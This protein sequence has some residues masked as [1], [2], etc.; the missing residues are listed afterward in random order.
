MPASTYF[1]GRII[2]L[3]SFL[4][5][6]SVVWITQVTNVVP[7]P[8]LDEV[9]HVPQAQAYWAGSWRRWD[10]K[11]T[12]PPGLYLYSY[13]VIR[14]A[15]LLGL[16]SDCR[17]LELRA[18]NWILLIT[19]PFLLARIYAQKNERAT[20]TRR[21]VH[22]ILNI[23]SFPLLFFF[24]ALYYTDL[25]STYVVLMTYYSHLRVVKSNGNGKALPRLLMLLCGLFALGIRQTNIFW[26]AIFLGGLHAVDT[27]Q[28]NNAGSTS[29]LSDS[30]LSAF[31][32][33]R[34]YDPIVADAPVEG[35]LH[36]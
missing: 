21:D 6:V 8:Y 11:I 16:A 34:I 27:L 26:A 10:P 9:F 3:A 2:F 7:E 12:T 32:L 4:F 24:S 17:T 25:L 13:A 14:T 23:C 30:V 19:L 33:G 29:G 22:G 28:R 18:T 35:I 31:N 36:Q 5:V 20:L 1:S 15:A